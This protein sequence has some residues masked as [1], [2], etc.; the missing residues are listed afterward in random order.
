MAA[1]GR[2]AVDPRTR[3]LR[4]ALGSSRLAHRMCPWLEQDIVQLRA[5]LE[6]RREA[7]REGCR[8]FRR[9]ENF[10]AGPERWG[11]RKFGQ[12]R[13]SMR[14]E[15]RKIRMLE[16]RLESLRQRFRR[17]CGGGRPGELP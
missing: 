10:S 16:D 8:R 15:E 12:E 5:Q 2:P 14:L 11:V 6:Q 1:L 3:W 9:G 4:R 13:D 7:Y 17:H